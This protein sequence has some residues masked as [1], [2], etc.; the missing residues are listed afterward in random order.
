[1][2][3]H[4]RLAK[5]LRDPFDLWL[6]VMTRATWAH[7]QG[8]LDDSERCSQEALALARRAAG[9]QSAEE[10]ADICGMVQAFSVRRE[11]G[12]LDGFEQTAVQ[13]ADRYVTVPGVRTVAI[14]VFVEL[15]R[16][17]EARQQF[18]RLA[19]SDFAI[20]PR[21]VLWIGA[22][23]MLAQAAVALGDTKRGEILYELML[24]FE[25]RTAVSV[26]PLCSGAI[27]RYLGLLAA[28]LG[29]WDDAQRHFEAGLEM[30]GRL[31]A[32]GFV[33]HTQADYATM[34]AARDDGPQTRQQALSLAREALATARELGFVPLTERALALALRLEGVGQAPLPDGTDVAG[35]RPGE[36]AF[37]QEGDY[38]TIAFAARTVR[39][40]TSKGLAMLAILLRR[41]GVA[42]RAIDLVVH[43]EPEGDEQRP[44]WFGDAGEVLDARAKRAYERRAEQ[45]S[46][47]LVQARSVGD[48][49]SAATVKEELGFL[50][51]ELA[52][53][54]GIGG[55]HRRA[56]SNDERARVS[57]TRALRAAIAKISDVHPTL[58]RHLQI[59]IR[60]GAMCVYVPDPRV[61]ASWL[62]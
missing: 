47:L 27:A 30:N 60:T 13:W 43:E 39:L 46:E 17:A 3:E 37:A 52:R 31:G 18:E 1:L 26:S 8:R 22:I 44:R 11:R 59:T 16:D 4:G 40:R 34:L 12:T 57:A 33:A 61:P 20:L 62:S 54:V 7:L 51:S 55:R 56:A 29:R 41:P 45:L 5:E 9:Q 14:A 38:W 49:E 6:S 28:M 58:G 36:Y 53:G 10:N 21:D 42:V 15:G 35:G 50:A 2:R 24:P 23:P 25:H 48:G 19:A 32:R